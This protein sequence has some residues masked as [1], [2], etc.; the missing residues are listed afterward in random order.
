MLT[1]SCEFGE[2]NCKNSSYYKED[3]QLKCVLCSLAPG[4]EELKFNYWKPVSLNIKH[5]VLEAQKVKTRM[6]KAKHKSFIKLNVDKS[7]QANFKRAAVAE[8][9][10]NK[11][12]DVDATKN[13]GR[14]HKDGD[15]SGAGFITLDTKLQSKN[16]NPIINLDELQKVRSDAGRAG[17]PIGGLVLRNKHN[18]GTVVFLESDF[19]IIL[20]RLN[21]ERS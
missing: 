7:K 12:L 4:N 13:S 8:A 14:V 2:T 5:P 10:T 9:K 3:V 17:N 16:V 11:V 18:V 15:H 6:D 19:Q 21:N 1:T 20:E